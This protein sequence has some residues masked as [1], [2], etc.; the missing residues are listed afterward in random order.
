MSKF[1]KLNCA[2][3]FLVLMEDM[4]MFLKIATQLTCRRAS[5]YFK[6]SAEGLAV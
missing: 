1:I 6:V 4:D 3:F 2:V 5:K